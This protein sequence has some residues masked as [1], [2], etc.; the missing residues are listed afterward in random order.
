MKSG[1]GD[2]CQAT[3]LG[4]MTTEELARFVQ[5]VSAEEFSDDTQE[6]LKKR[7]LDSVGIAINALEA[8]PAE[9]VHQTVQRVN[10]G[11]DCTLW[12]RSETA[13]PVGAAMHNTALTRYLDFM[14]SFLAPGE[15]PHPSDNIG[16]VVAV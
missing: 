16:A 1:Q 7:V 4:D 14:D 2:F 12:G 11:D 10:P 13:S 9:V 5:E 6:E 3:V 8:E 15:T